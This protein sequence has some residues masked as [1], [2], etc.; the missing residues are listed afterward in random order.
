MWREGSRVGTAEKRRSLSCARLNVSKGNRWAPSSTQEDER[1]TRPLFIHD[2]I[3]VLRHPVPLTVPDDTLNGTQY[4]TLN[5]SDRQIAISKI[6]RSEPSVIGTD[7]AE[8]IGVGLRTARRE[9][10]SLQDKGLISREG[11]DKTGCWI[12]NERTE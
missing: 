12:V 3:P 11:S 7:I 2:V 5:L 4:D 8:R 10:K 9:L 6:L 1:K